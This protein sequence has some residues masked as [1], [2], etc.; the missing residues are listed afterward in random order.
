MSKNCTIMVVS[1][2]ME[3]DELKNVCD[4][5]AK[6]Q[7]IT[8]VMISAKTSHVYE[9]VGSDKQLG[10]DN[11]IKIISASVMPIRIKFE[12]DKFMKK[13]AFEF[14][15]YN[16]FKIILSQEPK[17]SVEDILDGYNS[18]ENMLTAVVVPDFRWITQTIKDIKKKSPN[19]QK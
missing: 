8:N 5:Y 9:Y 17:V 4:T 2:D 10:V 3:S 14:N 6:E 13:N 18:D 19:Y 15:L 1:S 11:V 16:T 12:L 7:D